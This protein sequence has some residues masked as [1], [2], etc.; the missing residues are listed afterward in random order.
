MA[1]MFADN[2]LKQ[3]INEVISNKDKIQDWKA[4]WYGLTK[5]ML[6][7]YPVFQ[8]YA[9]IE[10]AIEEVADEDWFTNKFPPEIFKEKKETRRYKTKD[11]LKDL[12]NTKLKITDIA[13]RYGLEVD[14]KGKVICPFHYDSQPSLVL[15]DKR[16][17]FHCFGCGTKGNIIKFNMKL[18]Q[19]KGG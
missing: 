14:K 5:C 9:D 3:I 1:D 6:R 8:I 7:K 17:I 4:T 13:K 18:K 16:N 11:R 2:L 10:K 15:D 12:I 19:M